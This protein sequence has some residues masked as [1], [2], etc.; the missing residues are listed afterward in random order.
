[1]SLLARSIRVGEGIAWPDTISRAVIRSLVARTRRNLDAQGPNDAVFAEAMRAFPIAESSDKAN[2]QHYEI[3]AEFF[4]HVLGPYRKYSCCRF[5]GGDTLAQAEA[6]ALAETA[7]HADFRDGQRILELGCGWGSLSLW[8]ANAFPNARITAVSN[9]HSQRGYIV[10]QAAARGLK[11]LD[12]ITADMNAFE[13]PG[14][15]DRIVSVEMFEHMTNWWP[16]LER[17]RDAL[18]PDGRL[19]LHIF[20][21]TFAS[22]RFDPD[23]AADWIAQHFFTSGIMPS[24]NLLAEFSS[25]FTIEQSWRWSGLDYARTADHWLAAFDA[26]IGAIRPILRDTYG[27]EA[28]LWERRWRLFFLATSELFGHAGGDVWGVSHYRLKPA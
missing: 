28:S 13:P 15:Y 25:L 26:N 27:A 21:H 6:R 7:T 2:A 22:Y 24:E 19:F 18:D 4:A 20:T 1:M 5:E 9:S 12:V 10:E 14:Q 16:L 8:I 11:N 17:L 23:N 3:P